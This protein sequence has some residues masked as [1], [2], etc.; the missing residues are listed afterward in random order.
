MEDGKGEEGKCS[1]WEMELFNLKSVNDLLRL[2]ASS[3]SGGVVL[4]FWSE[5]I[6]MYVLGTFSGN[7]GSLKPDV[8]SYV[9]VKDE[10]R[11][12]FL[13]YRADENGEKYYASEAPTP[14]E[15]IAIP[16]IRLKGEPN[17]FAE[18]ISVET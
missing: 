16:H 14:T 5:K 17:W 10:I 13:I 6:G 4:G 18:R 1:E 12:G 8:F 15:G 2:I 7:Y 3:N 9:A 11:E